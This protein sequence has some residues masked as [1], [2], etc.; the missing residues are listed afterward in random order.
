MKKDLRN[1]REYS[2]KMQKQNTDPV[3]AAC[4]CQGE[5]HLKMEGGRKSYIA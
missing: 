2:I 1:E 5:G 3:P 4:D